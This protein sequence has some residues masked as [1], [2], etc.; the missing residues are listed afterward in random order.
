VSDE[1]EEI[2]SLYADDGG[3]ALE[4]AEDALLTL[5][6]DA[7]D[8]DAIAGLFRAL[9]TFKGNS[10]ILGLC[11]IE[12]CAHAAEDLVG[13][14]RDDGVVLDVDMTK[15]LLEAVDSLR[16]MLEEAVASRRD[17]R[18]DLV[19][20]VVDRMREMH[21]WRSATTSE[22][23]RASEESVDSAIFSRPEGRLCDDPLYLEIFLELAAKALD[24]LA[25]AAALPAEEGRTA[26]IAAMIPL[27]DAADRIGLD[28]W[29]SEVDTFVAAAE[30]RDIASEAMRFRVLFEEERAR[31]ACADATIVTQEA[32]VPDFEMSPS[33]A[34]AAA[35]LS[36]AARSAGY[37]GLAAASDSVSSAQDSEAFAHAAFSLYNQLVLIEDMEPGPQLCTLLAAW[38]EAQ[39]GDTLDSLTD[40]IDRKAP[41]DLDLPHIRR[42]LEHFRCICHARGLTAAQD[43]AGALVDLVARAADGA[44]WSA[45]VLGE[46]LT[47]FLE[48]AEPSLTGSSEVVEPLLSKTSAALARLRPVGASPALDRLCLPRAFEE[49]MT[50]ESR[51][52]AEAALQEGL[53]FFMIR[54]DTERQPDIALPFLEWVTA[55]TRVIGSAT[56]FDADSTLFDFLIAGSME[57]PAV[58]AAL[59]GFDPNGDALTI[60]ASMCPQ[61]DP[62]AGQDAETAPARAGANLLE[63]VGEIV[64]AQAAFGHTLR[65]L[66]MLDAAAAIESVVRGAADTSLV[67]TDSLAQLGH[68]K[69]GMEEL[70]Q[71]EARVAA[72]LERLQQD[73]VASRLHPGRRLLAPLERVAHAAAAQAGG[74]ILVTLTGEDA[75]IDADALDAFDT[76]LTSLVRLCAGQAPFGADPLR[77]GVALSQSESRTMAT[78]D[79]QGPR[80]DAL[81]AIWDDPLDARGADIRRVLRARGGEIVVRAPSRDRMR[82]E[83]ALSRAM[84][85]LESLIVRI[86]AVHYALPIRS[87]KR[88][89]HLGRENV[90]VLSANGGQTV[91]RLDGGVFAP[92]IQLPQEANAAQSAASPEAALLFIVLVEGEK[93][94]SLQVDEIVGQQP[95]LVRPLEGC[96]SKVRGV[97]G[98]VLL[99]DGGFGMVVDTS[100]LFAQQSIA[101]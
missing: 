79:A 73:I 62:E 78:V 83:I 85:V 9:H 84:T 27:R 19:S 76:P 17:C 55:H 63:S 29:A 92:V 20:D 53:R 41:D 95:L 46:A 60:L 93:M 5:R 6:A 56:V 81:R 80:A 72:G 22:A 94:L 1:F 96:L 59:R 2:W 49:S 74:D 31:F 42:L 86:G 25:A 3:Q 90:L 71:L 37:F 47:L 87:V 58:E 12:A 64:A 28:S 67:A 26:A 10:R 98:S 34:D 14:V 57:A 35:A 33:I 23:E 24:D 30:P 91:L 100:A 61:S 32:C 99:S 43:V 69:A 21:A 68:W 38:C 44:A 13:L 82:F 48:A 52:A 75:E 88:I 89:M 11:A 36:A 18:A 40:A 4:A 70:L 15:L 97:T 66:A 45:P 7:G 51:S 77:L 16:G 50:P 8:R 101:A 54:A 39:A 65:R